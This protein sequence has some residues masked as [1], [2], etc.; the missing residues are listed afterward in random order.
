MVH[1]TGSTVF[2]SLFA[3][4][5]TRADNL[6]IQQLCA[7]AT[8]CLLA[9]RSGLSPR[10]K[11]DSRR[12]GH[13]R[14]LAITVSCLC[15]T[16][17]ERFPQWKPALTACWLRQSTPRSSTVLVVGHGRSPVA[18]NIPPSFAIPN[19]GAGGWNC[20]ELVVRREL[21]DA[22]EEHGML[23][24]TKLPSPEIAGRT[25]NA[26]VKLASIKPQKTSMKTFEIR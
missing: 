12:T 2:L 25:R 3:I 17:A 4:A 7:N 18:K 21:L 5:L 15:Q 10:R 16:P 23:A 19:R 6:Q 13:L 20:D 24:Y 26:F 11:S 14:R 9:V 8:T 1:E 22:F